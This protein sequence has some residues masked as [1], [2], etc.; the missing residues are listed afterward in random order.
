MLLVCSDSQTQ[1]MSGIMCL[2]LCVAKSDHSTER[3][4]KVF[5]C[6]IVVVVVDMPFNRR[7]GSF[8]TPLL[9]QRASGS[10]V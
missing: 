6:A 5:S 1:T 10:R 7:S 2:S 4:C 8:S 3:L 9:W